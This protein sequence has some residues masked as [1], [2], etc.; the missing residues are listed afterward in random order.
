M[1]DRRTARRVV[2]FTFAFVVLVVLCCPIATAFAEPTAAETTAN[3]RAG[4][5]YEVNDSFKDATAIS[6]PTRFDATLHHAADVDVYSFTLDNATSLACTLTAP[7]SSDYRMRLCDS[8]GG[9]LQE[10]AGGTG[11]QSIRKEVPSG[12]YFAVIESADGSFEGAAAY[13]LSLQRLMSPGAVASLDLSEMNMLTALSDHDSGFAWDLGANGGGNFLMS[14]AYFS[15][16]AGPVAEEIDPYREEKPFEYTNVSA[17]AP[18]YVQNALYLPIDTR[19]NYIDNLK[20]AVFCYGAADIF[21]ESALLYWTPGDKNLFVDKNDYDYPAIKEGTLFDGGHIVT[22]VGWDDAYSKDNFTGNPE[23]AKAFGYADAVFPKPLKDGAFIVKNSW[24]SDA[25]DQGYFYLSY[26]DAFMMSNNPAV[27]MADDLPDSYNRQ[28][29]NDVFGMVSTLDGKGAFTTAEVFVND[30]PRDETLEAVSFQIGE[31]ARYSISVKTEEG[32]Q[33]VASGEKRYGGFYTTRL[34]SDLVVA[35]GKAFRVDVTLSPLESG[36]TISIGC[37]QNIDDLVSGVLK[38]EGRAFEIEGDTITDLGKAGIYPCIRAYTNDV[39]TTTH[40]ETLLFDA[41]GVRSPATEE[42]ILEACASV[43]LVEQSPQSS[44][45]LALKTQGGIT[46]DTEQADRFGGVAASIKGG[47]GVTAPLSGL[48]TRFDLREEGTMTPVRNQ[49]DLGS[50][51]TFAAMACAENYLARTGGNATNYPTALFLDAS[52]KALA[53]GVGEEVPVA[54]SAT[55][56]D[57]VNPTTT[58]INWTISGDVDS[59]RVNQTYSF[60][61]ES[62]PVVTALKPGV[63]FLEAASDADMNIKA[64]CRLEITEQGVESLAIEPGSL[65]L[66]PDEKSQLK[67]TITPENAV[68]GDVSWESSQPE[69]ASVNAEGMVVA[70]A[71]GKTV[72]TARVGELVATASVTVTKQMMPPD[73]TGGGEHAGGDAAYLVK[74]GDGLGGAAGCLMASV[75]VACG[76]VGMFCVRKQ[77]EEGRGPSRLR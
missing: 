47:L 16:W 57:T 39:A 22:V 12:T 71:P 36:G 48:P 35:S 31:G 56:A 44:A 54:L 7:N 29:S 30:G 67:A 11:S 28:Y 51:W 10:S 45:E 76:A 65:A 74:A 18:Y 46:Y 17:S 60:I 53:L 70:Y 75:V 50:C 41:A 40:S 23:A 68:H 64:Q 52:S 13:T 73:D 25:G 14:Q 19:E 63:V 49:G 9:Q 8:E 62:T 38:V 3:S 1:N 59:V 55:Y 6:F 32:E 21:V 72:I 24:G 15:R 77:K 26:E 58:R 61:G 69:V 33:V 66:K 34:K 37:S 2:S 27:F 42:D 20:S 43:G 5:R 4:D